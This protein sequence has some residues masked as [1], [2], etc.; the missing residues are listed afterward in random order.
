MN[1]A[2]KKMLILLILMQISYLLAAA[3]LTEVLAIDEGNKSCTI[4]FSLSES[5]AHQI[6]TQAGGKSFKVIFPKTTNQA[7]Q[8]NYRR[9]SP[10]I[11]RIISEQE[12]GNAVVNIR[13]MQ[14]CKLV[15]HQKSKNLVLEL[16]CTGAP[17]SVAKTKKV[18]KKSASSKTKARPAQAE[19]RP[20]SIL[21]IAIDSPKDSIKADTL[22][23]QKPAE[24]KPKSTIPIQE[25]LIFAQKRKLWLIVSAS[26]LLLIVLSLLIFKRKTKQI[27][28]EVVSQN[29]APP[30]KQELKPEHTSTEA[31][32]TQSPVTI[33]MA[34]RLAQQG[35]TADEISIELK[36][37]ASQAQEIID[38][39]EK[40]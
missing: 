7:L 19:S 34:Q 38:Q 9:L 10:V 15:E 24:S 1:F 40:P 17:A 20:D 36:I 35:W 4:I 32:E 16:S 37:P 26:I 21:T 30:E 23:K 28:F 22:S 29:D 33:K 27:Y 6:V 13:T 18:P 14:N 8:P 5:S 2:N 12:N 3:V 39:S 25:W 11:D 31:A